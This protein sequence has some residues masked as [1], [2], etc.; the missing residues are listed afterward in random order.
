MFKW[1]KKFKKDD[2]DTHT[3]K[4]NGVVYTEHELD[5]L[6]KE[7]NNALFKRLNAD[8]CLP[9]EYLFNTLFVYY[10]VIR[11]KCTSFEDELY[12]NKEQIKQK[13]RCIEILEQRLS[14]LSADIDLVNTSLRN[15][16]EINKK[17]QN[18]L[19]EQK[20]DFDRLVIKFNK[21]ITYTNVQ[22]IEINDNFKNF[23]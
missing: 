5:L 10:D 19:D 13:E 1:F 12:L 9:N 6:R 8:K 3:Y 17:Y 18:K 7:H 4:I 14:Q 20:N 22:A 2:E 23:D 15:Q 11:D 21:L 16:I